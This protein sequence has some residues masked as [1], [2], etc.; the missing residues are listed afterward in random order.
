MV[1]ELRGH[2]RATSH[3]SNPN[4]ALK[5]PHLCIAYQFLPLAFKEQ[6]TNVVMYSFPEPTLLSCSYGSGM[7]IENG[8]SVVK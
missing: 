5:T 3:P 4:S 2:T 1:S 8:Y 6:L 7:E